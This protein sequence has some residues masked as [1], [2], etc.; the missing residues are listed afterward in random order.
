MSWN[1][2]TTN[3]KEDN[4]WNIPTKIKQEEPEYFG[5][6]PGI[7]GMQSGKIPWQYHKEIKEAVIVAMNRESIEEHEIRVTVLYL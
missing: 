7:G 1:L 6:F 5:S 3:K 4:K 2:P